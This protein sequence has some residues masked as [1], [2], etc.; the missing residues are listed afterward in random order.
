MPDNNFEKRLQEQMEGFKLQPSEQVWSEVEL[1]IRKKKDRRRIIFWWLVPALLIGGGIFTAVKFLNNGDKEMLS[2]NEIIKTAKKESTPAEIKSKPGNDLTIQQNKIIADPVIPKE[3]FM[4]DNITA[5]STPA[6]KPSIVTTATDK[7]DYSQKIFIKEQKDFRKNVVINKKETAFD[8]NKNNENDFNMSVADPVVEKENEKK[9]DAKPVP[10]EKPAAE[11]IVISNSSKPE[12]NN[13]QIVSEPENKQQPLIILTATASDKISIQAV[14]IVKM[15]VDSGTAPAAQKAVVKL[16][17][18]W[19]FGFSFELG[20]SDLRT[21]LIPGTGNQQKSAL[22]VF[23]TSPG[24]VTIPR[25][26]EERTGAAFSIKSFAQKN[27]SKRLA[28]QAGINY[29]YFSTII[30][31]G[32]RVDATR[33][34]NYVARDVQVVSGFYNS[35]AASSVKNHY[36]NRYH[37][38]GLYGQLNWRITDWKKKAAIYWNN[39]LS[40]NQL[41]ASNALVYDQTGSV[42]YKNFDAFQKQMA[43]ISSALSFRFYNTS[44]L[45]ITAGPFMQYYLTPQ[46]KEAGPDNKHF[47]NYGI[48]MQVLF[49]K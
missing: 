16:K 38:A 36:I 18:K 25:A 44:K 6:N 35:T 31:V 5:N 11:L 33:A 30:N 24:V 34:L 7:N 48:N 26:S 28:V 13:K 46:L 23:Q 49:K 21:S 10:E 37:L 17:K 47:R 3:N 15:A 45:S 27:I 8:I 43:G 42:Y 39:G 19:Q 41:F 32:N 29:S 4:N 1:H 12:I 2:A 20:A 14:D 40:I 9:A 22:A